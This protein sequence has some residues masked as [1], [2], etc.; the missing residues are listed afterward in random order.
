MNIF[1]T[2]IL[3]INQQNIF[4]LPKN[5]AKPFECRVQCLAKAVCN[6]HND[7]SIKRK[8]KSKKKK[9]RRKNERNSQL[10]KDKIN[11]KS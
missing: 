4:L 10:K 11:E 1:F 3:L 9:K 5:R 6:C 2:H 8:A 7:A